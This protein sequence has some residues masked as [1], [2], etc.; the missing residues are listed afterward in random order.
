MKIVLI[1]KNG[2]LGWEFQQILPAFG[3]LIAL[4]RADLDVSDQ[5]AVQR[6]LLELQ[7][8]LI[9]NTSAYTKV[10]LAETQIELAEK[11]NAIS[12]GA[13][14]EAARKTRAV[15]IHYSTDYVFD[16]T[17]SQPYTE[18]DT[19]NP[20]NVYGRSKLLG[21]EN[22]R[23]A[24]DTY[25]IFRTSWVYSL[26][27]NSFVNKVLGWSRKNKVL[28]IVSDQVGSPTWAQM[29]AEITCEAVFNNTVDLLNTLRARR[30]IYHLTSSGYTSRYEWAKRIL[31]DDSKRT[32]QLVQTIEPVSSLEFPTPAARPLFSVLN[33]EKF[34]ETFGLRPPNWEES[35]QAAMSEQ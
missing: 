31:A 4:G 32:E 25:L 3:E 18:S 27:G 28:R 9:I 21:E 30:G 16:G 22:I 14:A 17:A 2:Q 10:D 11:I 23:Q 33:C 8:N 20:L 35:L 12:P 34:T 7:P 15:F 6:T 29:L 1:G 24:G 13:M 19:A 5:H 26:L